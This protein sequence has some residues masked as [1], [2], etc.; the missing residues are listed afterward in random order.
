MHR[1]GR[2]ARAGKSGENILLLTPEEHEKGYMDFLKR[3]QNV[4]EMKEYKMEF[5]QLD[6]EVIRKIQ[7]KDKRNFEFAMKAFPAFVEAYKVYI[8]YCGSSFSIH[9]LIGQIC[10]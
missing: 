2:T 1:A 4:G 10:D 8:L 3:N 6:I 5:A 7:I 9:P